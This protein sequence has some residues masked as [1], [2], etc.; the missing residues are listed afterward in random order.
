MKK[1]LA[2]KSLNNK[3]IRIF[4]LVSIIVL[5]FGL[6]SPNLPSNDAYFYAIITKNIVI[7]NSWINLT[8]NHTDWLD[9]PHL[10]FWIGA[11]F[12]K[13]FGVKVF[14][15]ILSG[16]IFFLIGGIYN[17]KLAK[18]IFKS[19]EVG[20]IATLIYFTSLHLLISSI[21]IRQEVYLLALITASCYYWYKYYNY[22]GINWDKLIKGS[23]FTALSI[24]IKGIFVISTI[25]GGVLFLIL[26]K[27]EAKSIFTKK[28]LYAILLSLLF[29]SPEI[30]TL[31][32]Q[33]DMH[34]EK[35]IYGKHGVSGVKW[36]FWDSQFGRFFD[37]GPINMQQKSPYQHYFYYIHT[38]LWAFLPWSIV[39]I[40]ALWDTI[41]SF[42]L[43]NDVLQIH[44]LKQNYVFLLGCFLP[45]FILFSLTKFQLDHYINILIPF[46][47]IFC[48][49][50]LYNK[51]T[52]KFSHYVFYIQISI[53]FILVLLVIL[54]S[55][56]LFN[57][58]DFI[59]LLSICASVIIIFA[60]L[61]YNH[62]LTKAIIYPILAIYCV[63]F[64]I[65]MTNSKL[66]IQYDLGYQISKYIEEKNLTNL[67]IVD[68]NIDNLST[69]FL[70]NFD[71][72]RIDRIESLSKIHSS[73]YLIAKK[74]EISNI[75]END[76]DKCSYENLKEFDYIRQENF[77]K[78]LFNLKYKE[79][80]L[81]KI[82]L[83][84]CD[85]KNI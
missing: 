58:V 54:I 56:I 71:Y 36:F 32:I 1:I 21:D 24:M 27:R 25:F 79:Q 59:I 57:G 70:V 52:R 20:L 72:Q 74:S 49:D 55:S 38:Y 3:L 47:A 9:K 6:Y 73:Y 40:I 31:I 2:A 61:H 51:A 23:I 64:L 15:Y 43:S 85:Y 13:I 68:Y 5:A 67:H 69:E 42:K 81:Q 4:I 50:W 60:I 18:E 26:Y 11:V 35:L 53:S 83:L 62:S 34:P 66:Y 76:S 29:I 84:K 45:T 19:K 33:F 28:W 48:A 17:F 63:F 14:S 8:F 77:I 80:N 75:I 12:Y 30:I 7:D 41:K 78:T 39:F 82:V 16:F 10:Q 46:S 37:F 44:L 65:L 22:N